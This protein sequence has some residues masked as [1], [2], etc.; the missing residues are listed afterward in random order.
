M[1][2]A[3]S[4]LA[5][6]SAPPERLTLAPAF[7]DGTVRGILHVHSTRSDGVGTPDAIAR[8]A[9]DAGLA[10]VV[11]TDHGDATRTPDPPAYVNGV[12]VL[13]GVEISTTAGHY[14]ALDMP[15]AP[16]PLGGEGRDVVEDVARLG[17]FGIVAHPDS[18]KPALAW[19]DWNAPF[20]AIE[21]VNLDTAW[22]RRVADPGVA[23]KLRLIGDA[24]GSLLRAPETIATMASP[25]QAQLHWTALAA[26]RRIVIA[27]GT[28]AHGGLTLG[29]AGN[30]EG[31]F[32]PL[33]LP[34]YA[35]AFRAMS[36]HVR[37]G[38]PFSG[39]AA[40][41]AAAL[42]RALRAGHL[43]VSMDGL[44]G[45]AAF[46]FSAADA[47]GEARA[48]DELLPGGPVTLH[49]RS[50]APPGY[51]TT[52][53]RNA[54][55]LGDPHPEHDF[56]ITVGAEPAFYRV[57]ID[58][59][60]AGGAS[61]PWVF[62]NP[63]Y[64]RASEAAPRTATDPHA[65]TVA[66]LFAGVGDL[67]AWHVETDAASVAAVDPAEPESG[68]EL[69]FRWGLPGAP[70]AQQYAALVGAWPAAAPRGDQLAFDARSDEP[71]RISV[72]LRVYRPD[73]DAPRWQR[74][75]YLDPE[76]RTVRLPYR[77]F[78]EP[79]DA[80]GMPEGAWTDVMFVVNTLHAPMGASGRLWFRN[81]RV[82]R[83]DPGPAR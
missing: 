60:R 35:A 49:V 8:A 43:Y 39:R 26:D 3:A 27:A 37:T 1:L 20:D 83:L 78:T 75:V 62:S 15:A 74:S 17:G 40:D 65:V 14:V 11:L 24:L 25:G 9:A 73:A 5:I 57:V 2:V 54:Q 32:V 79:A 81:V 64:V 29:G 47:V 69:R 71:T 41:D 30:G 21:L 44:A 82:E 58:A 80:A 7:D 16:Y 19:H 70:R 52:I 55:P 53:W 46:E 51:V 63:I 31:G 22:R 76:W 56:T 50:N 61:L 18:P 34:G 38:A 4:L 68:A 12:L 6:A 45:P 67:A 59:P 72:Q 48:G 28:D 42:F 23:A 10:F 13:D 33:P 66:T 77:E 36:V